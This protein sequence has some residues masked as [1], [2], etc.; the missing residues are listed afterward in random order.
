MNEEYG[1]NRY[2]DGRRMAEGV[3]VHADSLTEAV[4]KAKALFHPWDE[5]DTLELRQLR[6]NAT[7][8]KL[9]TREQVCLV[10]GQP[11]GHW[12]HW[13]NVPGEHYVVPVHAEQSDFHSFQSN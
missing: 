2:R 7:V 9:F 6:E 12:R 3:R 11:S 4:R 13:P 10:C 5:R 1:F 8:V